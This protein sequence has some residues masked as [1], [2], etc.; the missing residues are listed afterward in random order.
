MT[1]GSVPS[2]FEAIGRRAFR[3]CLRSRSASNRSLMMYTE[4]LARQ[5]SPKAAAAR[6]A[7]GRSIH[8]LA[9]MSAANTT[10]FLIHW[11]G[12]IE[13]T[14][15]ASVEAREVQTSTAVLATISSSSGG[16]AEA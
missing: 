3:G 11:R 10:R 7:S 14:M 8:F 4:P 13:T 9:K 2:A 1:A 16:S 15:P 6:P 12:R 5:N